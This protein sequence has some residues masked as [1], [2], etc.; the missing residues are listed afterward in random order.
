MLNTTDISSARGKASAKRND[1]Q[2]EPKVG[3]VADD[4]DMKSTSDEVELDDLSDD[5]LQD[6]E[7]TGLTGKVKGRRKHKKRQNTQLDH[8]IAGDIK[9]TDE[10]KKE[11]DQN[12]FKRSLV[13]GILIGLWYIF[14]LS[15]SIVSCR[16]WQ[17]SF[18]RLLIP[19]YS[20]TSG[21]FQPTTSTSS[22]PYLQPVCICWCSSVCR[23]SFYIFCRSSDHDTTLFQIPITPRPQI[24]TW[25]NMKQTPRSR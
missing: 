20:T 4:D 9:I 11:A 15:I 6:D 12:V 2:E 14:S 5:G 25:H 17:T 10:E 16:S 13:N 7:E 22:S 24:R 19:L 8:R 1:L 21:C 18:P 3:E 23:P